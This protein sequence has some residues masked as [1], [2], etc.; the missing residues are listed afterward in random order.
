MMAVMDPL[1]A[2]EFIRKV[3]Q[4]G[5]EKENSRVVSVRFPYGKADETVGFSSKCEVH[6][7]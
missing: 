6:E 2:V 5:D 4:K 1:S 3:S 7:S